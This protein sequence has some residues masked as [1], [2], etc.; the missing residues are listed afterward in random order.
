MVLEGLKHDVVLGMEFLRAHNPHV[1]WVSRSITV[2][3]IGTVVGF[4]APGRA[5]KVELC[6]L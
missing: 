3:N 1:D 5:A 2:A 6:S 4:A